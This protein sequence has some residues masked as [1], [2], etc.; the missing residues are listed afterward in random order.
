MNVTD[1]NVLGEGDIDCLWRRSASHKR[2]RLLCEA[3]HLEVMVTL[4]DKEGFVQ[5][6]RR[7]TC[8][9]TNLPS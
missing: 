2:D 4:A 1:R 5:R 8:L 9:A 3:T 7:G 6:A